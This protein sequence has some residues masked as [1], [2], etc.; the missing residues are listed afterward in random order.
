MFKN[1]F[2]SFVYF[3]SI[4]LV[5]TFIFTI[6]Y[7][8]NLVSDS[9]NSIIKFIIPIISISVSSFILGMKSVKKGYVEGIKLSIIVILFFSVIG[10]LFGSFNFNTVIYY[11]ILVLSS[12]LSGMLGINRKKDCC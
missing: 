1:L 9:I 4:F 12:S 10:M 6:F 3:I 7:Y 2:F 11:L 5:S 8:F